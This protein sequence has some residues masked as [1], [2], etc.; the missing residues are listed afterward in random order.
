MQDSLSG[1]AMVQRLQQGTDLLCRCVQ[2]LKF[3]VDQPITRAAGYFCLPMA[4]SLLVTIL[5][6]TTGALVRP[7]Y[8][9]RFVDSCC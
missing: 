2:S 1:V 6:M 4:D 5:T 7:L 8:G 9:S 3:N